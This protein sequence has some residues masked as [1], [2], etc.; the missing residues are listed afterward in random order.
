MLICPGRV[1]ER[2]QTP[3]V[4]HNLGQQKFWDWTHL[5]SKMETI[6]FPVAVHLTEGIL[7]ETQP[8]V[9]W[10]LWCA[11]AQVRPHRFPHTVI[12]SAVAKSWSWYLCWTNLFSFS[13]LSLLLKTAKAISN[14]WFIGVWGPPFAFCH[15]PLMSAADCRI[16]CTANRDCSSGEL[17]SVLVYFWKASTREPPKKAG[18][19]S[20]PW[21]SFLTLLN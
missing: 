2:A 21:V 6:L 14:N 18:F 10:G 8:F 9:S 7:I 16:K 17:G 4:L 13:A 12:T 20:F 19:A 1:I 5:P 3:S 11:F 15:F